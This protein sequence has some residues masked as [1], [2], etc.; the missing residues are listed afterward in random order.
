MQE[1]MECAKCPQ[2]LIVTVPLGV[3]VLL[4]LKGAALQTSGHWWP[5]L[6]IQW[7]CAVH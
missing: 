6:E 7:A 5:C 4:M 2:M 3:A 1:L